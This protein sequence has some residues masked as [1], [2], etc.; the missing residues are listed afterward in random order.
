MDYEQVYIKTNG[1]IEDL[2]PGKDLISIKELVDKICDMSIDIHNLEEEIENLQSK[3]L[4][5]QADEEE[6]WKWGVE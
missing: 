4:Q 3:L 1:D 6:K 5:D 2:F